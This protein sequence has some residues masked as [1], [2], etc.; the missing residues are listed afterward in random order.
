ML[1]DLLKN[2]LMIFIINNNYR[3][4]K[5]CNIKRVLKRYYHINDRI[6]QKQRKKYARFKDLDNRLK[7]LEERLSL[8]NKLTS[9]TQKTNKIFSNE[10]FS[11]PLE[12][13]YPINKTDVY[14]IGNLWGLDILDLKDNGPENNRG[15]RYVLVVFDNF[16]KFGWTIRSKIKNSQTLKDSF[17]N[18]LASSKKN[19]I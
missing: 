10:I 11:N 4:C 16:S 3:E 9:M 17:E 2:V 12:K 1:F 15:Y 14:Y 7:A 19:Q 18:I 6:L 13:N 8:K 5:E